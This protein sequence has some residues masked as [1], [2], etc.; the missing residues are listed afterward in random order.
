MLR[1][2][3]FLWGVAAPSMGGAGISRNA[4]ESGATGGEQRS[5]FVEHFG[6]K[7]DG[8][9]D[10]TSALL[11]AHA[12]FAEEC[13]TGVPCRLV[14]AP[15]N[16]RISKPLPLP[17][18][19]NWV[20]EALG[21]VKFI[22]LSSNCAIF[23]IVVTQCR[24]RFKIIG[25]WIF[26]W[27]DYQ[28]SS[29]VNSIGISIGC[30]GDVVDG[31]YG[32]YIENVVFPNG[33]RGI[34]VSQDALSKGLKF[35]I[36]GY[37]IQ[38]ASSY[39]GMSGATIALYSPN[40]NVGSPRAEIKNFY[41]QGARSAEPRIILKGVSQLLMGNVEFNKGRGTQAFFQYCRQ[42][43]IDNLR[44]EQAASLSSGERIISFSGSETQATIRCVEIQA[45]DVELLQDGDECYFINM[46]KGFLSVSNFSVLN[47]STRRGSLFVLNVTSGGVATY[48]GDLFM[49]GEGRTYLHSRTAA[50]FIQPESLQQVFFGGGAEAPRKASDLQV[51]DEVVVGVTSYLIG[52]RVSL[53]KPVA[54]GY[55]SIAAQKNGDVLG[56]GGGEVKIEEGQAG[57]AHYEPCWKGFQA[58]EKAHRFAVG[59]RLSFSLKGVRLPPSGPGT[60]SIVALMARVPR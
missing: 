32:F 54:A 13:A 33:Y 39:D 4:L 60:V 19:S 50:P 11:S 20:V 3:E 9:A 29:N 46:D 57:G 22:Q 48:G 43:V 58:A 45:H 5:I 51:G 27:E 15:G 55:L 31:V 35:P 42:I 34:A 18:A 26:S 41:C 21:F 17:D 56:S 30:D 10:D 52:F 6:A 2:R 24:S 16:Y 14:Y 53:K 59:D 49:S 28:D 7:G 8:V 40:P 1:R 38:S 36:W 47:I 23:K 44:V 37:V 25:S 12:M